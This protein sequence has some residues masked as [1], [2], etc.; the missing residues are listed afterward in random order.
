[1]P[2][3]TLN[4]T[5]TDLLRLGDHD[6]LHARCR[7]ASPRCPRTRCRASR[8]RRRTAAPARCAPS[9]LTPPSAM[10]GTRLADRHRGSATSASTCGTPKFVVQPRRAAAAGT[11]ADLDAV[12]AAVDQ[13]L[14]ALGGRDVARRSA[15]HRRT[16]ARNCLD[17]PLH[18]QRVA[19]RDVDDDDVGAGALSSSA[20]R[21]R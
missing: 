14:R 21:S 20:A 4:G 13:E 10:S 7:P 12:D 5:C 15:R 3:N 2:R 8:C 17:G 6:R 19:V 1:M 11:D 9:R 18:H 16:A